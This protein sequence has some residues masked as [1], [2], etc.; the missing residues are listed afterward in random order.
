MKKFQQI[1]AIFLIILLVGLYVATFITG[2]MANEASHLLFNF[3]VTMTFVI[4]IAMYVLMMFSKMFKKSMREE[5]EKQAKFQQ[6]TAQED[7]K[8]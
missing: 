4:P 3:S 8:D 2:L 5:M 7:N 1:F 6:E